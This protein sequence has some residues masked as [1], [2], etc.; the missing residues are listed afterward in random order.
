VLEKNGIKKQFWL[1]KKKLYA[2]LALRFCWELTKGNC[3]FYLFF[4]LD[5]FAEANRLLND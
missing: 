1:T 3:G 5:C 4:W 2:N